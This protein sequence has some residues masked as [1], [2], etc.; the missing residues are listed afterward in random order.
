MTSVKTA[1][2]LEEGLLERIDRRAEELSV[3]RS[4]FMAE[5]AEDRL[6]RQESREM[7]ARLDE[8]YSEPESPT[9]RARRQA[10]LKK[11]AQQ[12]GEDW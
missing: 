2:S 3:S 5:A 9:D 10:L 7:K 8:V 6:R 4:R 1:I 12:L 11:R